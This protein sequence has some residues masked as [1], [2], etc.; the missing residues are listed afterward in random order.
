MAKRK[1]VRELPSNIIKQ[2]VTLAASGFSLVAALAW[3]DLIKSVIETYVKPYAA[4]GSGVLA[5]LIYA[6]AVTILVVL[7]TYQLAWIQEK[8]EKK[9]EEK[10]N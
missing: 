9:E 1:P 10:K 4:R 6:I 8:F 7:M 3:N 2:M 5:Q